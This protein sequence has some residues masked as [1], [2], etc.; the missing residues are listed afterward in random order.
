LLI[1]QKACVRV[2]VIMRVGHE[3]CVHTLPDFFRGKG[4]RHE[5]VVA[6]IWR[7]LDGRTNPRMV[8]HGVHEKGLAA[9]LDDQRSVADQA[10]AHR[11]FAPKT[12]LAA[13]TVLQ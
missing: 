4:K 6:R 2:P 5:W 1:Q 7:I 13:S 9:V 8:E 12:S 3:Q 11:H 10:Q